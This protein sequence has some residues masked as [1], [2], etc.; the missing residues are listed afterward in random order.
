M[1]KHLRNIIDK[2]LLTKQPFE[3][4]LLKITESIFLRCLFKS[5]SFT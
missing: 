4:E 3:D 2:Y 1:N 5:F